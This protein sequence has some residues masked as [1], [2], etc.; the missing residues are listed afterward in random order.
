MSATV[1]GDRL[2][3]LEG[4]IDA[5]S[6]H[7]GYVTDQLQEMEARRKQWDE[8]RADMAPIATEVFQM[9][10]LELDEIKD[11]VTPDDL[12]RLV[13]HLARNLRNL[14]AL[15]GQLESMADLARDAMPLTNHMMLQAMESLDDLERKGYF[16]FV[17]GA[18]DVADRVVTSFDEEDIAALG[19]N[20]VLILE[21]VKEM[22][23]P[24]IMRLVG[25][26]V[27]SVREAEAEE[28]GLFRFMWRMRDPKVR[29]GLSKVLAVLE[30]MSGDEPDDEAADG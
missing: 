20:I 27:H 13:K 17:R 24:E 11:F 9:A 7:L 26:T 15:L 14:E 19:D 8:L 18:K 10:A 3:A 28:I 2:D 30:S 21:T 1:T 23:Q 5:L 12:L 29:R 25:R 4:K 16:S 22:T 6:D